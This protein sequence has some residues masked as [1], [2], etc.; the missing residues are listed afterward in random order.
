[1]SSPEDGQHNVSVQGFP[2]LDIGNGG[3]E[4][5]P[6]TSSYSARNQSGLTT[7]L[8]VCAGTGLLCFLT[9]CILRT[10]FF[11][12]SRL[13]FYYYAIFI[14][15]VLSLSRSLSLTRSTILPLSKISLKGVTITK[16]IYFPYFF[17]F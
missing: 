5:I 14:I 8:M 17:Y 15:I 2:F 3:F 6:G 11:Q 4:N 7:Q 13:L 9:F 12:S 16:Q 1:M 10:R